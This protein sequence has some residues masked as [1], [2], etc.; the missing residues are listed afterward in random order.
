MPK[1]RTTMGRCCWN[2]GGRAGK[3]TE[4][5]PIYS[6]PHGYAR[7]SVQ[8][9][10]LGLSTGP[11]FGGDGAAKDQPYPD[12]CSEVPGGSVVAPKPGGQGAA[13]FTADR[14]RGAPGP[15]MAAPSRRGGG[16]SPRPSGAGRGG[17]DADAGPPPRPQPAL[18]SPSLPLPGPEAPPEP[19]AGRSRP[20]SGRER[21]LGARDPPPPPVALVAPP[22]QSSPAPPPRS[23]SGCRWRGGGGGRGAPREGDPRAEG[24][25]LASSPLPSPLTLRPEGLAR[26]GAPQVL[27]RPGGAEVPALPVLRPAD[28]RQ[29]DTG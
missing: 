28:L 24:L 9:P 7:D 10:V 29:V 13:A 20:R 21:P 8:P 18:S 4:K 11:V 5:E 14:L 17:G 2:R 15:P 27:Q 19:P 26:R 12:G 22:R 25:R 23:W 6:P 3:G 16:C 1:S